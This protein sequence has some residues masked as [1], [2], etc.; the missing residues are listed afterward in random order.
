MGTGR[1]FLELNLSR[2][3]L[4]VLILIVVLLA[5]AADFVAICH[6]KIRSLDDHRSCSSLVDEIVEVC[7]LLGDNRDVV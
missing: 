3:N 1:R 5:F 2:A 6:L 7:G 4:F